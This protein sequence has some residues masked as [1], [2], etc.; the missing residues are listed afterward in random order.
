L[1]EDRYPGFVWPTTCQFMNR[2]DQ[3]T[4]HSEHRQGPIPWRQ[5]NTMKEAELPRDDKEQRL[6]HRSV[7]NPQLRPSF[8]ARHEMDGDRRERPRPMLRI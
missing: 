3:T 5:I 6:Q 2:S 1:V 4:P 7:M 8:S